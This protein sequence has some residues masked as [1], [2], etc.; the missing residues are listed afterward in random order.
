M[1]LKG[2]GVPQQEGLGS[3]SPPP[4]AHFPDSCGWRPLIQ[5]VAIWGGRASHS[6]QAFGPMGQSSIPPS[7]L[8]E[9]P[10]PIAILSGSPAF[11]LRC[12]F[13]TTTP[14]PPTQIDN[15][16]DSRTA[17]QSEVQLG[18]MILV[19]PNASPSPTPPPRSFLCLREKLSL[20]SSAPPP[21]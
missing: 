18:N 2:L 20:R 3:S 10:C 16:S 15:S 19:V 11:S 4:T 14:H 9:R 6:A 17:A 21:S 8:W 1:L 12:L 7:K 13:T 5:T